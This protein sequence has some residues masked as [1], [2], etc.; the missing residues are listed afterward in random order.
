MATDA[1]LSI[2]K[3]NDEVLCLS[4]LGDFLS[5]EFTGKDHDDIFYLNGFKRDIGN[6]IS[7]HRSKPYKLGQ[8][9]EMLQKYKYDLI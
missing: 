4:I 5:R 9:V 7:M 1:L 3:A 2:A 8:A 6:V